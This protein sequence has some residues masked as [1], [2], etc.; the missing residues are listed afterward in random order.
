MHSS[1][2]RGLTVGIATLLLA[3]CSNQGPGP[4]EGKWTATAPF[5]VTVAFR[6]GEM[7]AMGT[8]RRVSY[9]TEGDNVV[10]VTYEDGANN[11]KTFRYTVI[12]ADTVRSN[13]GVFHRVEP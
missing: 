5:P 7:E 9:A 1:F 10:L 6:A 13:S 2:L 12:D 3:A 11:G 4:L 8:T